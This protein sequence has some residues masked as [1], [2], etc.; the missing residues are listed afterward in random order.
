M[1]EKKSKEMDPKKKTKTKSSAN[2][3]SKKAGLL[4]PVGTIDR[5]LVRG[6]RLYDIRIQLL[7]H[8]LI[9]MRTYVL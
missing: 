4:F 6:E 2:S 5:R 8:Y 7:K 3:R 1:D 9:G